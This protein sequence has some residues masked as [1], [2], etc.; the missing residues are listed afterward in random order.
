MRKLIAGMKVSADGKVE[1]PDGAGFV[2]GYL[3]GTMERRRGLELR[4]VEKLPGG[5]VSLIY[6]VG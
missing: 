5:C 2:R 4:S 3:F 1:G 6:G